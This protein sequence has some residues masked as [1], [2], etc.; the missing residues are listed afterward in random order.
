MKK[1]YIM[2]VLLLIGFGIVTTMAFELNTP[3]VEAPEAYS[4]VDSGTAAIVS[5]V[6]IRPSKG[7][8]RIVITLGL[9]NMTATNN[10]AVAV[11]LN[12]EAG[13][14]GYYDLSSP[15]AVSPAANGFEE[16]TNGYY[17]TT[18]T[19][20]AGTGTLVIKLDKT[21]IWI[22]VDGLMIMVSDA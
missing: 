21:N 11:E 13:T 1:Q 17:E 22:D 18:Y 3:A 15:D 7:G 6:R 12:D 14:D 4:I 19:A 8:D 9:T 2:T 20:V 16:Y 10:Y 5:S